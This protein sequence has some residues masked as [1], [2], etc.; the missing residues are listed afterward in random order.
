MTA[1]DMS[2]V[3]PRARLAKSGRREGLNVW[4]VDDKLATFVA[5][6]AGQ[7]PH[8]NELWK[9]RMLHTLET[10]L[11]EAAEPHAVRICFGTSLIV[12]FTMCAHLIAS[13]SC[14]FLCTWLF[15]CQLHSSFKLP[16]NEQFLTSPP[17][18]SLGAPREPAARIF[19]ASVLLSPV[20]RAV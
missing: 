16:L 14:D 12:K 10:Q 7:L 11:A 13:R 20:C 5:G 15:G 17:A 2:G 4:M 6:A 19:E 3:R 1:A 9:M 18:S 8:Q